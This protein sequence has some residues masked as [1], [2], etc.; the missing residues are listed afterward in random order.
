MTSE[1]F[2]NCIKFFRGN[3]EVRVKAFPDQ[4]KRFLHHG[5][6][7]MFWSWDGPNVHTGAKVGFLRLRCPPTYSPD[8]HKVIE[9]V[10]GFV[11]TEFHKRWSAFKGERTLPAA[12]ELLETIHKEM[13]TAEGI[14]KDC[15][16]LPE[17]WADIRRHEGGWA[18]KKL[19]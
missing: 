17:T 18:E 3:A 15:D 9:H 16:S 6:V 2:A 14:K 13:I 10:H 11:K 5:R 4:R 1:E 7:L 8:I 19:R 12:W